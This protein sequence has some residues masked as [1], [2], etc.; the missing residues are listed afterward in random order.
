MYS[1]GSE[2]H[3]QGD[4]VNYFDIT[5]DKGNQVKDINYDKEKIKTK[6]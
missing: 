6:I 2:Y 3:D 4:S 1:E 5:N